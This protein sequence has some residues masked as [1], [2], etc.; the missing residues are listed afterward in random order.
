[1]FERFF[2]WVLK[3]GSRVLFVAALI[4]VLVGVGQGIQAIVSRTDSRAVT[5]AGRILE[6]LSEVWPLVLGYVFDALSIASLPFFGALVIHR[7]DQW[8]S[9]DG[10]AVVADLAAP[11]RS[12]LARHG[13]RLLF[14]L[15][16]IYFAAAAWLFVEWLEQIRSAK[17]S[18]FTNRLPW[19][20]PLWSG[21]ILLFASLV[22]DRLDH[23]LATFRPTSR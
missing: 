11:A 10:V 14:I 21:S 5:H 16:C 1:M 23:W 2:Q 4:L 7:I 17:V 3:N 13:S 15:S 18:A 12:W 22:L 9:K 19:L 20:G 8:T 6:A